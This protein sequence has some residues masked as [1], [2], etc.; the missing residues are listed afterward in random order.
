MV[1]MSVKSFYQKGFLT[2]M[3]F[4]NEEEYL[5]M[6]R[7]EVEV[8]ETYNDQLIPEQHRELET[9][10]DTEKVEPFA[11][12]IDETL[13][14]EDDEPAP[15]ID[16]VLSSEVVSVFAGA[17][18]VGKSYV[19]LDWAIHIAGGLDWNGF[20]VQEPRS[21]VY[22]AGE[23]WRSFPPR[24]RR[25]LES[26]DE[27]VTDDVRSRLKEHLF[28]VDGSKRGIDMSVKGMDEYLRVKLKDYNPDLIIFDTFSMLAGV[29]S[30][31][32]NS[33]VA[34][35]FSRADSIRSQL[36]TT[37][38]FI[39]H[40][41]K[42]GRQIRGASSFLGNVDTAIIANRNKQLDCFYLST[43]SEDG[44]KQR[45]M[46]PRRIDGFHIDSPGVLLKYTN[47]EMAEML[48]EKN[49]ENGK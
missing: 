26:H 1:Y 9:S 4:L 37:V 11:S 6:M 10:E 30:E 44:A 27:E 2:T 13:A 39:H 40:L 19:A 21:V 28:F 43:E 32:D 36:N 12:D 16:G 38:M 7:G 48:A 42:D 46:K 34:N 25:W 22:I 41:S 18:G 29:N 24:L 45:E 49:K 17:P 5:D 3:A 14:M 31:N 20:S 15:L 23:G 33:E 35:V 8:L 47:D